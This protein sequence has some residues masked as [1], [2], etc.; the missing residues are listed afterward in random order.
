M[1]TTCAD[2]GDTFTPAR[3]DAAYC[4][5]ACRQRAYRNRNAPSRNGS[6]GKASR[7]ATTRN[8]SPS[9]AS[10][11]ATAVTDPSV[12]EADIQRRI[13]A[14]VAADR[15]ARAPAFDY[16][17]FL[18]RKKEEDARIEQMVQSRLD[19][20]IGK[21]VRAEAVAMVERGEAFELA[22]TRAV[23]N[24]VRKVR[25]QLRAEYERSKN[26]RMCAADHKRIRAAL[27]PDRHGDCNADM[28]EAFR[29]FNDAAIPTLPTKP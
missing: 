11:N 12:A 27:H 5:S 2:C 14:A 9:T 16:A 18:A 28:T 10:R 19:A 6:P 21:R 1:S 26:F 24:R 25:E 13:D 3:A 15:A 20:E 29:L 22:V 23:E 17:T 4:S 8:G 7:N